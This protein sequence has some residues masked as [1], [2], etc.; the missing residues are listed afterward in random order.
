MAATKSEIASSLSQRCPGWLQPLQHAR[1]LGLTPRHGWIVIQAGGRIGKWVPA[2]IVTPGYKPRHD[3]DLSAFRGLDCEVLIDDET[4]YG[5]VHGL[6]AGIKNANPRRLL[7]LTC[8][9]LPAI[10][11]LKKGGVHGPQ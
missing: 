8:G 1:K 4:G 10:V 6:V 3:D 7:L 11:I 5:L 9:R 2:V